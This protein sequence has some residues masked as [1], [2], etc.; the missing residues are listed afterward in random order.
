MNDRWKIII[1]I[2]IFILIVTIPFNYSIIFSTDSSGA[3]DLEIFPQAGEECVRSKD[4]MRPYHMNLLDQWR[5]SVVREGDRFTEGPMGNR[6][7]KSLT[8]TCL[9]CHA[10]KENFCDRCHDYMS[11]DPYCWDCHIT[12]SEKEGSQ[13]THLREF[14]GG[15]K[16][17]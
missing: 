13:M 12:P 14:S 4:Y 10:N 8:N 17:R 2:I 3:P 16:G 6:I 15:E 7:E 5:D 9:D 11:V 1:G